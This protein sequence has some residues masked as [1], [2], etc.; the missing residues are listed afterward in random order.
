MNT[1]KSVLALGATVW[2][3]TDLMMMVENDP[4]KP[5]HNLQATCPY[6]SQHPTTL[7]R[8]LW[9]PASHQV[10]IKWDLPVLLKKSHKF[11]WRMPGNHVGVSRPSLL[12]LLYLSRI[13]QAQLL[14]PWICQGF[15]QTS[16]LLATYCLLCCLT[17]CLCLHFFSGR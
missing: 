7:S 3:S 6:P 14:Y 16:A 17:C 10:Y 4:R 8:F 9:L 2:T 11:P 12:N 5:E 1:S 15:S 13:G